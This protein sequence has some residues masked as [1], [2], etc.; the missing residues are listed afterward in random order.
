MISKIELDFMR[1]RLVTTIYD[2]DNVNVS[3]KVLV[4]RKRMQVL[5]FSCFLCGKSDNKKYKFKI[6]VNEK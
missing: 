2:E 3:I 5:F 6:Y 4:M 1:R